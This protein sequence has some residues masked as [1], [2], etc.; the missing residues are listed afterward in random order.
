VRKTID[1]IDRELVPLL[2]ER[3][4]A[5]RAAAAFKTTRAAVRAPR[6]HRRLQV[7]RV[8]LPSEP[9]APRTA[10]PRLKPA[11]ARSLP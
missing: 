8:D 1:A 9:R 2:A 11:A 4:V 6:Q 5:V 10:H 3:R 7:Q